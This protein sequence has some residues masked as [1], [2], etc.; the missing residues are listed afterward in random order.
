[1]QI[2]LEKGLVSRDDSQRSHV[3]EAAV[4]QQT[5]QSQLLRKVLDMAFEGSIAKLLQGAIQSHAA[6]AKE[7]RKIQKLIEEHQK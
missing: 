3:Y 7:L 6:S 1:M 5:S 2:M 4:S